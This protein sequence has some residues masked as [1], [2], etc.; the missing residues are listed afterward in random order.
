MRAITTT[1]VVLIIVRLPD[2]GGG[3][4]EN[5]VKHSLALISLRWMIREVADAQCGIQFDSD[6]LADAHIPAT[7]FS[8]SSFPLEQYFNSMKRPELVVRTT[9]PE[10]GEVTEPSSLGREISSFFKK[11]KAPAVNLNDDALQPISDQ[12]KASWPWWILEIMPTDY[13]WQD[14]KGLWHR[15]WG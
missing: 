3:S 5:S 6:A 8:R 1:N 14:D 11:A 13:T 15:R 7:V 4:V 12:L 2:V 10:M 9:E